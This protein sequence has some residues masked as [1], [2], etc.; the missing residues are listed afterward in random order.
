MKNIYL[1]VIIV[2]TLCLVVL[3]IIV[4]TGVKSSENSS[5][6]S[7]PAGNGEFPVTGP[8]DAEGVLRSPVPVPLTAQPQEATG[9]MNEASPQTQ[10]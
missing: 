7:Q 10:P 5:Q 1:T 4:F 2:L 8:E 3:S 9:A 6:S